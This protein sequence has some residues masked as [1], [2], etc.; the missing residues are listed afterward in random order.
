MIARNLNRVV[1]NLARHGQP[2]E[3]V[4][5][6]GIRRDSETAV[7]PKSETLGNFTTCIEWGGPSAKTWM[8]M[9]DSRV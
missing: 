8:E 7:T 2:C 5:L 9:E 3:N 4:I 6:R 1:Q